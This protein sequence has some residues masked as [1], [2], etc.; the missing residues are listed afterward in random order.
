MYTR[1]NAQPGNVAL[2]AVP[3]LRVSEI[4]AEGSPLA[5]QVQADELA[6]TPAELD[7]RGEFSLHAEACRVGEE[8][9]VGGILSGSVVRQC[10]RCL[11]EYEDICEVSFSA[12]YGAKQEPPTRPARRPGSASPEVPEEVAALMEGEQYTYSGDW[13]ELAPMLREQVI[14]GIPLQPLCREDCQGLCP[15]CGQDRNRRSCGCSEERPASPFRILQG[16][17][18]SSGRV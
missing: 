14:L 10:V 2:M 6:L 8:V 13:I 12:R 17:G 4:P 1:V 11:R 9:A 18:R 5:C 3:S 7:V 16:R 15:R